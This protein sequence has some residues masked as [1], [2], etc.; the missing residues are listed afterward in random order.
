M[1]TPWAVPMLQQWRQAKETKNYTKADQIRETLRA[2]GINPDDMG[3]LMGGGKGGG[4]GSGKGGGKGSGKGGGKGNAK[5]A[6]K[7][8]HKNYP[9]TQSTDHLSVGQIELLTQ[10]FDA[11]D[12]HNYDIA[13]GIR[14]RLRKDGIE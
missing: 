6:P 13:D 10:W 2:E 1:Q 11:K 14:D 8:D 4:K 9:G 3:D 7:H 12:Q 5:S